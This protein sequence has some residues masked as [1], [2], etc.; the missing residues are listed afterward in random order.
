MALFRSGSDHCYVVVRASMLRS[1]RSPASKLR[2]LGA[3]G[4]LTLLAGVAAAANAPPPGNAAT[5][6]GRGRYLVLAGDCASC[7]TK[8]GGQAFAGGMYMPTP[9][10]QISVPNITPDRDTGIGAWTDQQFYRALHEGIGRGGEYLYPVFPFP[11]Y[12]NITREDATAI[13]A[14][15]FSLPA[16]HSPRAP[17]RL[18]WPASVRE[19]L[20]AWRAAFFKPAAPAAAVHAS[21]QLARG[22][23]LVEGLGHCGE[24][25]NRNNVAGVSRWSGT[26]QGGQIEGWYA[27]N[28]TSDKAEGVGSW[29][30]AE[31]VKF[32]KTGA[33]PHAG[34][35]LGPM[36][37]VVERSLSHLSDDDLLAI[38]TYLKSVPARET[39]VDTAVPTDR[40]A[41]GGTYLT[42]CASC[43][44]TAGQGLKGEIPALV[45]NGAV[46]AG[47]PQ[48][49]M[50]VVMGGLPAARGMA[51][52]P[53]VGASMTDEQ[54]TEAIN[55]LRNSFG[56]AAPA[57][58]APGLAAQIR[59]ATHTTLA[60]NPPGGCP[61]PAE[62]V[63]AR[64]FEKSAVATQLAR[65]DDPHMVNVIDRLL[66]RIR[67]AAPGVDDSAVV[68]GL[69]DAYCQV[70]STATLGQ[71]ARAERIGNFAMLVYGQLKHPSHGG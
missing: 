41:E 10:G 68:N 4:A 69:T 62:A 70:L 57:S 51:P 21:P 6:V 71:A 54:V 56:N 55:Y 40:V 53:A 42:Y 58:D 64:A 60:G 5:L 16:V 28:I 1:Y 8:A 25:H 17:L 46:T 66:P 27:P 33:S 15:L 39:Y 49:V 65:M 29:S 59:A 13:R 63:L 37:E 45:G 50:R 23:Y 18:S 52:M 12:T 11:W 30:S 26:L 19:S 24:C 7:H 31:I 61:A 36:Q 67:A 3:L 2:R 34:I 32:L 35:A 14:Y 48:N 38:A 20:T 47:G 9:F 43:H 22:A 44:G